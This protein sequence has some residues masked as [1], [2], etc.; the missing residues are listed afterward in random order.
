MTAGEASMYL[1]A[2]RAGSPVD[3]DLSVKIKGSGT[4]LDQA[5]V[6]TLREA[7]GS[8]RK[9]WPDGLKN[10]KE[11]NIFEGKAARLTHS[12]LP[13]DPAVLSD[14]E[15]WIWLAV[16]CFPDTVEWR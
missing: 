10:F 2:K 5:F 7:L 9:T 1:A 6:A 8:L 15:F 13:A 16:V 11:G 4:D 12:I 14:S 3:A